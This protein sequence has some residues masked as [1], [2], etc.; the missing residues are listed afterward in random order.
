MPKEYIPGVEAGINSVMKRGVIAGFPVQGVKA[1]LCKNRTEL[2]NNV[3]TIDS[4]VSF[5]SHACFCVI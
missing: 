3:C 1:T 4:A 5:I 2:H